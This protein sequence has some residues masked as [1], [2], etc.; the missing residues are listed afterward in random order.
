MYT[1]VWSEN[2][3]RKYLRGKQKNIIILVRV[4]GWEV[5]DCIHLAHSRH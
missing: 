2:L 3:K 5:V 4:N 1:K